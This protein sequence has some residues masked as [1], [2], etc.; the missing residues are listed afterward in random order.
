[1][2]ANGEIPLGVLVVA[3]RMRA[4]GQWGL[5]LDRL[6]EGGRLHGGGVV[7]WHQLIELCQS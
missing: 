1:M 3:V 5:C 4:E 7:V 2:R 6:V